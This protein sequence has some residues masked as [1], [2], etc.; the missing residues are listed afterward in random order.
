MVIMNFSGFLL[1]LATSHP[2]LDGSWVV[3]FTTDDIAPSGSSLLAFICH[4]L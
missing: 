3:D 1:G 2:A 4:L